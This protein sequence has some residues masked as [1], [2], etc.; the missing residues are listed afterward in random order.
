MISARIISL[1][2]YFQCDQ[3]QPSCSRCI[4]LQ[5]SCIGSGVRRFTFKDE[6]SLV[7]ATHKDGSNT[8]SSCSLSPPSISRSPVGQ[9]AIMTSKLVSTLQIEDFRYD[10][11][12]YGFFLHKIP[13]R[14]GV[15]P[16]LDASV[17]AIIAS[18]AAL[19]T[20]E[21]SPDM[22][23]KYGQAL[24]TLRTCLTDPALAET[25]ETLCAIYLLTVC[26][27]WLAIKNPH[28]AHS[29]AMVHVLKVASRQ[30]WHKGFEAEMV[31]TLSAAL[32]LQSIANPKIILDEWFWKLI[33]LY[34]NKNP[35]SALQSLTMENLAKYNKFIR[36]PE[37]HIEAIK[38]AYQCLQEESLV[39]TAKNDAIVSSHDP[40]VLS[41]SR[42][43]MVCHGIILCLAIV[44]NR[45]LSILDPADQ[46]LI[47]QGSAYRDQ[48]IL[49][50]QQ[51]QHMRPLGAAFVP[52]CLVACWASTTD[53]EFRS[54]VAAIL[55]DYESD[56]DSDQWMN[57]SAWLEK[58]FDDFNLRLAT[59]IDPCLDAL[60]F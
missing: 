29:E 39:M 21:R 11:T 59:I 60:T 58:R 28:N 26:E 41:V 3:G 16:A 35:T 20:R 15:N 49:L 31:N 18:H 2:N 44:L 24:S 12:C 42:S 56:F 57:T 14:I 17:N 8:S 45:I 5:I 7:M 27:H 50:S 34:S 51:V 25:P 10:P 23:S 55:N 30:H 47:D 48:A 33:D 40:A 37:N 6:T 46:I 53:P 1:L 22:F 32:L 36:E 38:A 13:Q 19:Y 54:R 4:R 43:I 9:T 52:L